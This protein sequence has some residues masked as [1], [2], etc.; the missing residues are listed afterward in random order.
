MIKDFTSQLIIKDGDLDQLI[1]DYFN[2][3]Q[4]I[5]NFRIL[6]YS[7]QILEG[8]EFLHE[9]NKIHRDIKPK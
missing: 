3:N 2:R 7:Q 6:F 9:K 1:K 4:R 5:D 8:L